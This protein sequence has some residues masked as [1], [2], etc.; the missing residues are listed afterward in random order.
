MSCRDTTK[1]HRHGT[2]SGHAGLE[3][4]RTPGRGEGV[5]IH[6]HPLLSFS[7]SRYTTKYRSEPIGF[8]P[9]TTDRQTL[10]TIEPQ[11][12]SVVIGVGASRIKDG[13]RLTAEPITD[14][15]RDVS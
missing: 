10:R 4:A 7:T 6:R 12:R 1:C 8:S 15:R 5:L 13:L 14:L 3:A 11:A 2:V 9:T